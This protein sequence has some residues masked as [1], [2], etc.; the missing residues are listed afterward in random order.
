[1]NPQKGKVEQ[2]IWDEELDKMNRDKKAAEA[3]WGMIGFSMKFLLTKALKKNQTSNRASEPNQ[4]KY[5]L[6]LLPASRPHLHGLVDQVLY[7]VNPFTFLFTSS[8]QTL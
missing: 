3:A 2:I 4:R 8:Y 6:H 7:F 1:L 5:V